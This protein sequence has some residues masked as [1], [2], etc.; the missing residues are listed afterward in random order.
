MHW[1]GN[2]GEPGI[3]GMHGTSGLKVIV[4]WCIWK[5]FQ[6]IINSPSSFDEIN[7]LYPLR[8]VI[9]N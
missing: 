3:Q 4:I 6:R 1:Q 5:Y 9:W 8:K 2:K 7:I